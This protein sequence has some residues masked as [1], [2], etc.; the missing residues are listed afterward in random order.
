METINIHLGELTLK[1]KNRR[2]FE[3]RL[4]DNIKALVPDAKIKNLRGRILLYPKNPDSALESLK[5][6]FGISWFSKSLELP[7]NIKKIGEGISEHIEDEAVK[8]ETKRTDKKFPKT[9]IET[10]QEVAEYLY[11]KGKNPVVKNYEKLIL[12]EILHDKAVVTFDKIPGLGGLPY[13]SSGKVL[14]LL[15]GGIDSPVSAWLMMKRGCSM[16]FFHVHPFTNKKIR[17]SKMAELVG[18]LSE[19]SPNPLKLHVAPYDEFFKK[20]EY[21]TPSDRMIVFRRFI[22]RMADRIAKSRKAAGIVTGDSLGQVASQT[23]HNLSAVGAVSSLPVFRPLV[24]MDKQ[25]I[26]NI[27]NKIG[28]YDISI[29][30]YEDCCALVAE[31]HPSIKPEIRKIEEIEKEIEIEKIVEKTFRKT[32][33]ISI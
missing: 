21:I 12:I 8:I 27:G 2:L 22:F 6:V 9:S 14:N 1:G 26:I 4:I 3:K 24:G 5:K 25:E 11:E 29:K 7:K 30:P 13:G 33:S 20:I 31:K 18:K 16:E 32:E 17:K 10:S 28:T 19:Y 15:S 23:L